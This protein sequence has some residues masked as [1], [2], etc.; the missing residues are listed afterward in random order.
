[1]LSSLDAGTLGM[2]VALVGILS[3]IFGMVLESLVGEDGFGPIGNTIIITAGFF[4]GIYAANRWGIRFSDLNLAVAT[5]L[6][7]GFVAL[8]LLC[9]AKAAISSGFR[10]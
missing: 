9:V 5:G 1:M 10:S 2:A 8:S 7:G 6:A 4:A 3:L